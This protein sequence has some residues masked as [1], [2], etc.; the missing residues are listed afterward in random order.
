[1]RAYSFYAYFCTCNKN[2]PRDRNRVIWICA[3]FYIVNHSLTAFAA[4]N[5]LVTC[6]WPT[7]D[8]TIN[9]DRHYS[10]HPSAVG[11]LLPSSTAWAESGFWQLTWH[12]VLWFKQYLEIEVLEHTDI[13][14][15]R[16]HHHH[17]HFRLLL[18]A[19]TRNLIYKQTI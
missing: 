14:Q 2:G 8:K 11:R 3:N 7:V 18:S 13:F 5:F 15:I 19:D 1:M 12:C 10:P 16:H 17:H 6:F 4:N 9:D